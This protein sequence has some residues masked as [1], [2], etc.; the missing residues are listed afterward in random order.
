MGALAPTCQHT[1]LAVYV[2]DP[3]RA[4]TVPGMPMAAGGCRFEWEELRLREPDEASR[5]AIVETFTSL[6]FVQH[7]R[8]LDLVWASLFPRARATLR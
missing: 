2:G 4:S 7:S 5:A 6:E 8:R 3:Q 1:A